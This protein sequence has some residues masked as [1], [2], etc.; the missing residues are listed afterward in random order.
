MGKLNF[1]V[2]KN[3]CIGCGRCISDCS[4]EVLE[5]DENGL[6]KVIDGA[7]ERCMKCQHCFAICPT[8][9]ISIFGKNPDK[10]LKTFKIQSPEAVLNLMQSRKSIRKFK[11][12]NLSRTTLNELKNMLPWIPTGCNNHSL[13][14][15]FIEDM[16]S[17]KKFKKITYQ[18]MEEMIA[19]NPNTETAQ[20]MKTMLL[21]PYKTGKDRVFRNAPHALIVSSP[22]D[23]PCADI[24]PVI[25]LSYFELY[26]QSL[27]V[28]T[29]WCGL[30]CRCWKATPSIVDE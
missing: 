20:Q 7:E 2:D 14:F 24:D 8:G 17:M 25:A 28:G 12:E 13:A 23:A 18:K 26:A 10:S 16:E 22:V 4:C 19:Q 11:Q 21:E 29:L 1:K 5:R 6:P 27:G 30:L 15:T 3:K 9:A